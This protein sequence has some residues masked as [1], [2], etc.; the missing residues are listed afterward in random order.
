MKVRLAKITTALLAAASV[1]VQAAVAA[2]DANAPAPGSFYGKEAVDRYN[3]MIQ[4][5]FKVIQDAVTVY[6]QCME[7]QLAI[8]QRGGTT[9]A[10]CTAPNF[11]PPP[12]LQWLEN[13]PRKEQK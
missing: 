2:T 8:A 9:N 6:R 1:A 13:D 3:Q 12:T 7:M 10:T 4:L 11:A 5:Q